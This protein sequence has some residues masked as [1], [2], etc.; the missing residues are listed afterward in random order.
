MNNNNND[1]K[2]VIL[3]QKKNGFCKLRST[4]LVGVILLVDWVITFVSMVV[5]LM[6]LHD[7]SN[8]IGMSQC[9]SAEDST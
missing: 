5:I 8:G 1:A 4:H 6:L 2:L 3:Q 9:T 7:W